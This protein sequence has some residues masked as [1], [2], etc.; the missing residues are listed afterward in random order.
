[1]PEAMVR[2]GTAAAARRFE[3]PMEVPRK[4]SGGA[5]VYGKSDLPSTHDGL[6]PVVP[7]LLV[8]DAVDV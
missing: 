8:V 4:R 3:Y 1:M 5:R 2:G 6:F 7:G